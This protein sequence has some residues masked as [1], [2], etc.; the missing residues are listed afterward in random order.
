[1][2]CVIIATRCFLVSTV[3]WGV[4]GLARKRFFHLVASEEDRRLLVY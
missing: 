3:E 2:K 4:P 1:M